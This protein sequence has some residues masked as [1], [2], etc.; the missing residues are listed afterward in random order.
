MDSEKLV[1][2]KDLHVSFQT[3]QGLVR[4]VNGV[5]FSME[6]GKTLAIVGESGSGK[7]VTALSLM[8]LVESSQ[9]SIDSGLIFFEGREITKLSREEKRKL[10]GRDLS[11]IFQ[12]PMT[13]L[14]PSLKIGFQVAE[15][16]QKNLGLSKKEAQERAIEML[17]MVEIEEAE[18]KARSYPHELSGGQRQRVMIAMALASKPKV[19]IADEPTTALDVTIQ[20]EVLDLMK[21]LQK[22]MG[23][24]IL[25]I[26]H[27]LGVVAEMADQ[28]VV[29]YGGRAV[30]RAQVLDLFDRPSH[31][32]TQ[33]L[34]GARPSL[35][36]QGER[37]VNIPGQVPDP[38]NPIPGCAF[39]NRCPRAMEVCRTQAPV[40]RQVGPDHWVS[41]FLYEEV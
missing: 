26:T 4:A 31:P 8:G 11:M 22:E 39:A 1:E 24:A 21:K 17:K 36:G 23:T 20:A 19:L 15:V 10:R 38:R 7:S 30:E 41:C 12:E 37:L 18:K 32:Y 25:L 3:D 40:E 29:M 16:Y 6:R 2:V 34:L 9:G 14:N 35:T 27:D 5:S 13:S 33:G 28:V